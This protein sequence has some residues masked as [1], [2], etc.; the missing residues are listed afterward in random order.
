MSVASTLF[1][2][3]NRE[4]ALVAGL[5]TTWQVIK[6]TGLVTSAG[7]VVVTAG[8][9]AAIDLRTV[10]FAVGAVVV[11]AVLSGLFSASNIL[12]NG[13]PSTYTQTALATVPAATVAPTL[14]TFVAAPVPHAGTPLVPFDEVA[15]APASPIDPATGLPT[16]V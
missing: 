9:L 14:P 5:R 3:A 8:Q 15:A 13:L 12:V 1:P 16:G 2:A 6:G 7:Y 11:S 10:G 4:A